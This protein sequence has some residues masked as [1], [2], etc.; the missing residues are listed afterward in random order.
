MLKYKAIEVIDSQKE[1]RE[2]SKQNK[3]WKTLIVSNLLILKEN[4]Y[5]HSQSLE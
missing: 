3:S 1:K 4:N 5:S 2:K